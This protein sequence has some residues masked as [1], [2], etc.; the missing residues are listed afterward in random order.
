M[1]RRT[2]VLGSAVAAV[3][4]SV[5]TVL[6]GAGLLS[7]GHDQDQTLPLPDDRLKPTAVLPTGD[8]PLFTGGPAPSPRTSSRG[9]RGASASS[10]DASST[11]RSVAA[12]PADPPTSDAPRTPAPAPV[13]SR[14][15]D[16]A[17]V[18]ELQLRLKQEQ[19]YAPKADGVYDT[20]VQSAVARYQRIHNVSGDPTGAY[21]QNTRG[22][23][24]SRTTEP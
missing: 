21:G 15:D 14:G 18:L 20:D 13:L 6:L 4:L 16:G 8:G 19:T 9:E 2:V 23:L 5:G 24:E 1:S 12:R 17:E 22:V 3:A 11:P 10:A 7:G